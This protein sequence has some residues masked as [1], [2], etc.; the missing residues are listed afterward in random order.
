MK[1]VVIISRVFHTL[2]FGSFHLCILHSADT[3]R[4][5]KFSKPLDIIILRVLLPWACTVSLWDGGSWGLDRKGCV[6]WSGL[7]ISGSKGEWIWNVECLPWFFWDGTSTSRNRELEKFLEEE[8]KVEQP[9]QSVGWGHIDK[10]LRKHNRKNKSICWTL[11]DLS[12]YKVI[13]LERGLSSFTWHRIKVGCHLA[14][15]RNQHT[16]VGFRNSQEYF[17]NVFYL[18]DLLHG[19]AYMGLPALCVQ[20]L[21]FYFAWPWSRLKREILS[22]YFAFL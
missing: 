17:A 7:L 18:P 4:H 6:L 21:I 5:P 16:A 11:A 20:L 1:Y 8:K 2:L 19:E 10:I 13:G 14:I 15:I 22:C 3:M 12:Q 9:L